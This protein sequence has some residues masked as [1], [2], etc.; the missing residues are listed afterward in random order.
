MLMGPQ[1]GEIVGVQ[2]L[3]IHGTGLF[4][5][6]FRLDG[7]GDT[8]SARLGAEALYGLP[9]VGDRVVVHFMMQTVTQIE[10]EQAQVSG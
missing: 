8:R 9:Q 1:P 5:V 4:D 3:D 7:Q 10:R 2:P 6:T